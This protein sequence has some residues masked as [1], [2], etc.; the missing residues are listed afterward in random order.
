[1]F[2]NSIGMQQIKDNLHGRPMILWDHPVGGYQGCRH[3][4]TLCWEPRAVNSSHFHACSRSEY[5]FACLN[6]LLPGILSNLWFSTSFIFFYFCS[7]CAIKWCIMN[8]ESDLDVW[9][10]EFVF[11]LDLHSCLGI[12]RKNFSLSL[13]PHFCKLSSYSHVE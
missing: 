10:D 3:E 8:S 13:R 7:S 5:S 11:Q 12:Y 6:C 9:F 2:S 1:M 4:G